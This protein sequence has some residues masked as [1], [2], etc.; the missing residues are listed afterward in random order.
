MFSRVENYFIVEK[1]RLPLRSL[2]AVLEKQR[3][4]LETLD[5]N[6]FLL[7]IFQHTFLRTILEA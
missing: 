7:Q 2:F 1:Y 5:V 3:A 4:E 6:M